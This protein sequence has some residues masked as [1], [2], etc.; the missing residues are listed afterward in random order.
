MK[1]RSGFVSNSS[2]SS[3]I[4]STDKPD[5]GKTLTLTITVKASSLVEETIR[6]AEE[7]LKYYTDMHGDGFME[8]ADTRKEYETCLKEIVAG[9]TLLVMEVGNEDSNPISQALYEGSELAG[10]KILKE[11][12]LKFVAG[13]IG[14]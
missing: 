7:L 12:G 4:V 14:G 11:A 6:T 2:S 8:Y 13:Y 9:K 1:I 5:E 3:F 10:K